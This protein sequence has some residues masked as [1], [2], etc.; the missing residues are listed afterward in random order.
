MNHLYFDHE[1]E[2]AKVETIQGLQ[3]EKL[4][5]LI[6]KT[7]QV[8][9]FFRNHWNSVGVRPDKINSLEDFQE[10]IPLVEK[11]D[12]LLDQ[13]EYPP[14]GRRLEYALKLNEPLIICNTS[15]TSGQ[16]QEIHAQ[17][18]QEFQTTQ[19]VYGFG[20]RWA[21]LR[22][23]DSL[24]LTMPITL[25]PGGRCEYHGAVAYGLTVY[26]A[27]NYDANMKIDLLQRFGP[28]A[29]FGTT[30]YFAHLAAISDEQPPSPGLEILL[31]GGEHGGFSWLRRLEDVWYAK[32][33]DRY[34]STQSGND[35]MF[36]CE[37][38]IGSRGKLG[39]L[40][41][42]DPLH[43][44]E[45]INPETGRHVEHGERGEIVF[46]SLYRTD[47]PAIRVRMRDWGI[48]R[49][50]GTCFCGRPF[51]GVEI[52]SISRVDDMKKV[53][54]IN[55]FPQA[56]DDLMF[57]FTEVDEY[58]VVLSSD[59]TEADVAK[60]RV[61]T[62]APGA[63]KTSEQLKE[64]IAAALRRQIGISFSVEL[65]E[66]GT[67]KRSEYKARRWIDNRDR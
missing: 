12:F 39:T 21:G 65:V 43:L 7:Q 44:I 37:F 62:D 34:G 61:M 59:N 14:Y 17:T 15:G 54:G 33:F 16:G 19:K 42:I 41:N 29:L 47:T 27:G 49:A 28:K 23:G 55:I 38:G 9:A 36:S 13:S 45:V 57:E 52:C 2:T 22:R 53:K 11:Q 1:L 32:V 3:L 58:Q 63:G 50:P 35:H 40:H 46:T 31:T 30:S 8:N 6:Q 66:P 4:K 18:L 25:M 64:K 56:V 10:R 20:L 5:V 67:I 24:F 26:P 60:V 48:W 51:S